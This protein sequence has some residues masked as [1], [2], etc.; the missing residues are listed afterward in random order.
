M[1]EDKISCSKCGV[2]EEDGWAF[3]PEVADDVYWSITVHPDGLCT[4]C[5]NDEE[6][7]R[8]VASDEAALA[9]EDI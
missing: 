1:K 4:D 7:M 9:G 5:G 8:R 6:D 2:E 3:D